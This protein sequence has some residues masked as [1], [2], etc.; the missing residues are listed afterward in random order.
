MRR[1]SAA[2]IMPSVAFTIH[3]AQDCMSAPFLISINSGR[4]TYR[5]DAF[6]GDEVRLD[7]TASNVSGLPRRSTATVTVTYASTEIAKWN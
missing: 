5:R 4:I 7:K 2:M 1:T 3:Y 6:E